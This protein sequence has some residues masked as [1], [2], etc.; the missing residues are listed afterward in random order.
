MRRRIDVRIRLQCAHDRQK[1]R[2]REYG[3]AGLC[4]HDK[5]KD[6]CRECGGVRKTGALAADV[7]ETGGLRL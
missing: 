5:R 7:R 1:H 2:C 4:A 6:K 3:G